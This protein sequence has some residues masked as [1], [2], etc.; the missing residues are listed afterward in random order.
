[1]PASSVLS[2]NVPR[3]HHPA[4]RHIIFQCPAPGLFLMRSGIPL[5]HFIP[6]VLPSLVMIP[7]VVALGTSL[8]FLRINLRLTTHRILTPLKAYGHRRSGSVPAGPRS[9]SPYM[10]TSQSIPTFGTTT[11][12]YGGSR[13]QPSSPSK[14]WSSQSQ[15]YT[16]GTPWHSFLYLPPRSN[17]TG[18]RGP[19]RDLKAPTRQAKLLP[20]RTPSP[21]PMASP[22]P[23]PLPRV[24]H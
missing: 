1:M 18:S 20:T 8:P 9:L 15:S 22:I 24:L 5:C 3:T 16:Y 13:S 17:T 12:G 14:S 10:Q 6:E 4:P 2:L 21:L 19:T 7:Q 23:V 11:Y